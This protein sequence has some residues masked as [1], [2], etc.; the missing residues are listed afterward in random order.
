VS[1][2]VRCAALALV[3]CSA[4]E[5]AAAADGVTAERVDFAGASFDVVTV[6]VGRASV[7]VV[8]RDAAGA[9]LERF[10]RLRSVVGPRL[11]VAMNAGIFEPGLAP[12]GLLV[13]DGV[14]LA[15][16]NVRAGE[17]NFYLQPSGVFAIDDAGAWIVPTPQFAS[18][19]RVPQQATQSGPLLVSGGVIHPAFRAESTSVTLRN[20]VGVASSEWV[21]LAISREPVNLET[22]ARLFRDRLGCRDA[23]YL[24]GA[25]SGMWAPALGRMDDDRGP[26]GAFVVVE[27][28]R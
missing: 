6:E 5:P 28:R 23:L 7:R 18:A 19:G 21:V 8:A 27:S 1:L 3:A 10:P 11:A 14:E 9:A 2:G 25:I 13:S 22:F 17:G 20:G 4:C 12:T 15:P 16:L 24:D 26:F